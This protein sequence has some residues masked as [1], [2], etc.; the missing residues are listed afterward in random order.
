MLAMHREPLTRTL[1][2]TQNTKWR[3]CHVAEFCL[4]SGRA[5][6]TINCT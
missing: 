3:R 2:H 1:K 6:G 5:G 4:E